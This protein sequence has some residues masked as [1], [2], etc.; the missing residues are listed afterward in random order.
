MIT[1]WPC[2]GLSREQYRCQR[3]HGYPDAISLYDAVE[4]TVLPLMTF[5]RYQSLYFWCLALSV[6]VGLI[7]SS[8]DNLLQFFD[9]EEA[10]G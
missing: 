4:L 3:Y 2:Q 5:C 1:R 10:E 9:I 6:T 7:S 8:I